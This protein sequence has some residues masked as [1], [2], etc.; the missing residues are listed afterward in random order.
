VPVISAVSA[1]LAASGIIA[2]L[3]A[4]AI[5]A[6]LLATASA[7]AAGPSTLPT[8]HTAPHISITNTLTSVPR[9]TPV[10]PI[11]TARPPCHGYGYGYG[12]G[13]G[14]PPAPVDPQNPRFTVGPTDDQFDTTGNLNPG[15]GGG[16]TKPGKKPNLD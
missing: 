16:A 4:S 3:L 8:I 9:V 13:C 6:T 2:T 5:V 10:V 11:T 7:H 12:Y 15:G 14:G 1:G